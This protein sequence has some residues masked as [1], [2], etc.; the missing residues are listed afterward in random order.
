MAGIAHPAARTRGLLKNP[1]EW[2]QIALIVVYLGVLFTM[3]L[4]P[5]ARTL[6]MLAFA[7]WLA[8]LDSVV[9]HNSMHQGPF[10][11]ETLN[12]VWRC[13]IS[14]GVLYPASANIASHN[15]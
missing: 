6:P 7:C 15:L 10:A 5:A 3:S 14:F 8:F 9:V 13:L 12:G 1:A 11:S 4:V 2:R